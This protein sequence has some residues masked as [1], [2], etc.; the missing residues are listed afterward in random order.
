MLLSSGCKIFFILSQ[1]PGKFNW[2]LLKSSIFVFW[3]G[4]ILDNLDKMYYSDITSI[5]ERWGVSG[6]TIINLLWLVFPGGRDRLRLRGLPVPMG[7]P[8][9]DE[10]PDDHGSIGP[11]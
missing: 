2:K 11:H 3:D 10:Q 6:Y 4:E 1:S 5:S 9:E 8:P 7:T